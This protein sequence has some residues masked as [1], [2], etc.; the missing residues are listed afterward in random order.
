MSKITGG[1]QETKAKGWYM[2][3]EQ[4]RRSVKTSTQSSCVESMMNDRWPLLQQ[5]VRAGCENVKY[6]Q[7]LQLVCHY[8]VVCLPQGY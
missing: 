1:T 6:L 4:T 8:R 5:H 7:Y 3:D 2:V